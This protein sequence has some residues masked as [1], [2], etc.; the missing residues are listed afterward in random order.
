VRWH[1]VVAVGTPTFVL[2]AGG[3]AV[4]ESVML[5]TGVGATITRC[6]VADPAGNFLERLS[7]S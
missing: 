7:W 2:T 4:G 6:C 5:L 3:N 1:P